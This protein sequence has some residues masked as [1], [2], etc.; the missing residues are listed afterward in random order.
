MSLELAI[1]TSQGD[2]AKEL[3]LPQT[4]ES[5]ADILLVVIPAE[6]I[7]LHFGLK[8]EDFFMPLPVKLEI[9]H[10]AK[11]SCATFRSLKMILP[12]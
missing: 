8:A 5:L 12:R 3:V 1:L 6:A 4:E 7:F 9:V 10:F 2:V 11:K